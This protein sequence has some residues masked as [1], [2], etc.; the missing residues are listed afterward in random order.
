M[1][2]GQMCIISG[3]GDR[4]EIGYSTRNIAER[5]MGLNI[6]LNIALSKNRRI[7]Q[8]SLYRYHCTGIIKKIAVQEFRGKKTAERW[9][10]MLRIKK[11]KH[12]NMFH[13]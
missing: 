11:F 10:M 7:V 12:N 5:K 2:Y 1:F 9:A 8:I 3:T 4:G 13:I 6:V